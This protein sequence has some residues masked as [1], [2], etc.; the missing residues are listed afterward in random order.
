MRELLATLRKDIGI[1]DQN[2]S[3]SSDFNFFIFNY[4]SEFELII[5][6]Y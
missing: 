6:T 4:D 1:Q 2:E 5:K 3:I